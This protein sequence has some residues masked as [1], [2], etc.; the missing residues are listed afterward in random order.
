MSDRTV[1]SVTFF[2]GVADPDVNNL[3]GSCTLF[4]VKQGKRIT[5]ILVDAGLIQGSFHGFLNK[6]QEIL[7]QLNLKDIDFIILTHSH[8]DHIGRLPLFTKYGFKGR[9]ICTEGTANLLNVMLE[10]SAKIQMAEAGYLNAKAKKAGHDK[11]S[12][13]YK[14]S[15]CGKYDRVKL[16]N[17]KYRQKN[18][19]HYSPLYT[20]KDVADVEALVKNGGYGYYEWIGLSHNV[21]VKFYPSGHVMGG[22][23]VV[24]KVKNGQADLHLCFSGDL[25]RRDGIILPPPDL[26]EEKIGWLI[27]ESTYGGRMHPDRDKEIKKLL[28]IIRKA[29]KNKQRI[30]IPSFALER[31][32][33]IIYLLSYYMSKGEIP[34]IPIYLDSPLASRITTVFSEGWR[35]G[36]FSDQDRLGFNPFDILENPY[37]KIITEQKDSDALIAH[38]GPHVIIAGSG[39]CDAG[40]VRAHLRANAGNINTIICLVGYMAANSL[41]RKI[42]DGWR[43]VN[44]NKQEII[45]KA[46]VFSFDSL[47]A[48]ADHEFLVQYIL[49]VLAKNPDSDKRVF[50][51]HGEAKSAQDLRVGVEMELTQK[52][53]EKTRIAIPKLNQEFILT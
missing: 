16:L 52:L 7:E 42:K 23:I 11:Q 30:I 22:S 1:M 34:V 44:M 24:I 31:S 18:E 33:E 17:K 25:G 40:R 27:S 47:S 20:T 46:D 51:V 41:G 39:M 50:L 6:N 8:I 4:K 2:G 29:A 26:P 21:S 5:N 53:K 49:S 48:H 19:N 43:T 45:I 38:D 3:T 13:H 14:P 12:K 15:A 35:L 10:D 32:Q 37:L 28:D 9:I 36:M